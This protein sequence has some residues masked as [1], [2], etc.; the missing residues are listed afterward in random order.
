MAEQEAKDNAAK[1]R[2]ITHM[3]DDHHDSIIRYLEYYSKLPSWQAYDGRVSGIDLNG[4]TL[5]CR[6]K[7]YRIPFDPPMGSYREARERVVEMDKEALAGLGQSDI[8]VKEFLPPTGLYAL[9][10]AIIL[11]TFLGYSQRWWFAKGQVVEQYLGSGFASFSWA[12]QPYLITFMLVLHAAEMAYFMQN[13]LK[14]HAVNPRTSLFWIW[15][16][17]TFIEGVFAFRRFNG[18]VQKKREEKAKQK[19]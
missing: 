19:H 2:I 18:L 5:I 10:F 14:K 1:G 12:I 4:M 3:N 13:K 15:S 8:T 17:T 7:T 9:E 6:S 16:A 11:A